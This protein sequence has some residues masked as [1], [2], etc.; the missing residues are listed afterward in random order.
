ME[1]T[2]EDGNRAHKTKSLQYQSDISRLIANNNQIVSSKLA[3]ETDL[4]HANDT[5]HS[6]RAQVD[7]LQATSQGM[8][9]ELQNYRALDIRSKLA[10][11][12]G[13]RLMKL[14]MQSDANWYDPWSIP[15]F[16]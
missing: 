10:E 12:P 2:M 6:L 14:D 4:E 8:K 16:Q 11:R 5:V 1:S 13:D 3:L 15:H 9:A 7:E